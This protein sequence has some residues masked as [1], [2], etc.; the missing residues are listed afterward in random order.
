MAAENDSGYPL[1]VPG[2]KQGLRLRTHHDPDIHIS[3]R[4]REQG[5]WEPYET[6]LLLECLQPGDNF[7]DA[8]AN[9][10][11]F[12]VLA[13]NCVGEA[14]R[15]YAFEPE[16]RNFQLLLA[17]A[18]LNGFAGRITPVQAALS[19]SSGSGRLFLHPDNLGDHQLFLEDQ[20]RE[21]VP[22][23]MVSGA[24]WFGDSPPILNLVKIDTQGAEHQV[25]QGLLPVLKAS[26]KALRM[27]IELTPRSLRAAGSSGAELIAT[28]Q[29]LQLPF[30]IVDHIEHRLVP[31]SAAELSR[32]CSNVDEHPEDA[33]FMNIFLGATL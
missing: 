2:L 30:A 25:V 5:I 17:N 33:G 9:I 21:S 7:L 20:P 16:P 24:E 15:V 6:R 31:V 4:I 13:A 18:E 28:L 3:T 10:G 26:G 11:Y 32:W 23:D 22:V 1:T 8:G 19:T 12:S 29:E 27:I 14:G